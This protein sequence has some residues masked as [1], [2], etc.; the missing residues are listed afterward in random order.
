[1]YTD[2]NYTH[3]VTTCHDIVIDLSQ[4]VILND[5]IEESASTEAHPNE[6]ISGYVPRF[7]SKLV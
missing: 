4:L 3:I 2:I 1:M 7:V 5:S 6:Q